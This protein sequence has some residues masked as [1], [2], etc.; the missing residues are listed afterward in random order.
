[1]RTIKE[2]KTEYNIVSDKCDNWGSSMM[3]FFE[4]AGQMN[5]RG[6]NIPYEW[7]YSPGMGSDG[8]DVDSYW[9]DLF[10]ESTDSVLCNIGNLLHR[11]TQYLEFKGESY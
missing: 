11:Y 2:F 6:L 4:C 8:T 10:E 5:K 1:M 3:A 9:Y 7:A